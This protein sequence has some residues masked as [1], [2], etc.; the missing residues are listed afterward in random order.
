[1]TRRLATLD[2]LRGIA[3]IA[4]L[5]VHFPFAP[6]GVALAPKGYLAVDL[7]FMLSGFVIAQA[8]GDRLRSRPWFW[9]F[10]VTRL[11][12]LWPLYAF[13]SLIGIGVTAAFPAAWQDPTKWVSSLILTALFLPTPAQLSVQPES[14]YPFDFAAWSLFWELAVNIIYAAIA[15][16]LSTR[17]L[18][19]IVALGLAAIASICIA[20]YTVDGG[21]NWRGAVFGVVRSS[22]GFFA[23]VALFR[24]QQRRP[25]PSLPSFIPACVLILAL[26]LRPSSA[27]YDL[28]CLAV[29]FPLLIW[30][31]AEASSGRAALGPSLLLG[32]LSYPIYVLHSPLIDLTTQLR[33]GVRALAGVSLP[34]ALLL[35]IVSIL[36]IG[37][38]VGRLFDTPVRAWLNHRFTPHKPAP[39]AETAP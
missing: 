36:V 10:C 29:V 37:W 39:S 24:I 27:F 38:I 30:I 15:P 34:A 7:F 17:L 2:L 23:G 12:R 33:G 1:M 25:A 19:I 18:A 26:F 16:R 32:Y 6:D 22:Y 8:Y 13:A 28:A 3:A 20:G 31:S 21:A 14:L 5:C 4:V 11:I 35:Y 9:Q